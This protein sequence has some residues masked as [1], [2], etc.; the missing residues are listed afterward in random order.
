MRARTR[1]VWPALRQSLRID[2]PVPPVAPKM[3]TA[4]FGE[5]ILV[6]CCEEGVF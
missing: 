3:A 1:T 2:K 5:D 6:V 4:A